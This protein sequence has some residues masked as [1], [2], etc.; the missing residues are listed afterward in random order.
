M[1][2]KV[3]IKKWQDLATKELRGQTAGVLRLEHP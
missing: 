2:K 3:E 1:A